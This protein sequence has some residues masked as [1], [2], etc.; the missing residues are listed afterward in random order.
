MTLNTV[1]S[2]SIWNS[3][4]SGLQ[5]GF[6]HEHWQSCFKGL[7]VFLLDN[8]KNERKKKTLLPMDKNYT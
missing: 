8:I 5:I 4:Q 7:V 1:M 3:Y 6:S 2:K